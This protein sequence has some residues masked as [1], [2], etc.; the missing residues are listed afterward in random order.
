VGSGLLG[1]TLTAC[2]ASTPV[3]SVA[4]QRP[5]TGEPA[6]RSSAT[7]SSSLPS[8]VPTS[9]TASSSS[10]GALLALA[11]ARLQAEPV[12]VHF[13]QTDAPVPEQVS[14]TEAYDPLNDEASFSSTATIGSETVS[15][16]IIRIG[17][18]EWVESTPPGGGWHEESVPIAVPFPL[19]KLVPFLVDVHAIPG[20]TIDGRPAAGET[21][22]LDAAG[23]SA[24]YQQ[25]LGPA[26]VPGVQAVRALRFDVWVGPAH[27]VRELDETVTVTVNGQSSQVRITSF[28]RHWGQ[29]IDL[30]PPTAAG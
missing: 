28:Y 23:V 2:G 19:L 18:Q 10:G 13:T 27:H 17:A 30:Q 16:Q 7:A 20:K 29:G 4:A 24:L 6:G 5:S 8:G 12:E 26:V 15:T 11:G 25:L 1:L 9:A 21:A 22:T 14:G 3:R